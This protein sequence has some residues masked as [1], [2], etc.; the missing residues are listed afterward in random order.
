MGRKPAT[1]EHLCKEA[2][3]VE[4]IPFHKLFSLVTN[5][6]PEYTD[7]LKL[8][9][10]FRH[11]G[12]ELRPKSLFWTHLHHRYAVLAKRKVLDKD[13]HNLL[14]YTFCSHGYNIFWANTKL[15]ISLANRPSHLGLNGIEILEKPMTF[16]VEDICIFTSPNN[17]RTT[18]TSVAIGE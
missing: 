2:L 7:Q 15:Y 18:Y 5:L 6:K 4:E 12:K 13:G 9:N 11:D 8:L 10:F 3:E 14:L 17:D 1:L 16:Y